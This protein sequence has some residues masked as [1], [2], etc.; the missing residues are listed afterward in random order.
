MKIKQ[1]AERLNSVSARKKAK[2]LLAVTL[3]VLMVNPVTGYGVAASAQE[4]EPITAFAELP[5]EIASQ[6]LAVGAEESDIHLPDTL[7]VTVGVSSADTAEESQTDEPSDGDSTVSGNDAEEPQEDEDSTEDNTA[8]DSNATPVL[9]SGAAPILESSGTES[10]V[11]TTIGAAIYAD[12]EDLDNEPSE[13]TR[14]VTLENVEWKIDAANS[15]SDTFDS[16]ENGAYYT[17]VP[18]LP[19]GYVVAESVRLPQITVSVVTFSTAFTLQRSG[20]VSDV[21]GGLD[22]SSVKNRHRLY[23]QRRRCN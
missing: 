22:L 21:S 4:S 1:M 20:A 15:S 10:S 7:A 9:D 14:S 17:Y 11:E 23:H 6:Q 13:T 12:T 16:S 5:G 19:A 18:V 3:A 8:T 2:R